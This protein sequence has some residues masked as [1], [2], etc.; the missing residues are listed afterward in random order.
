GEILDYVPDFAF[1]VRMGPAVQGRLAGHSA[2]RWS[3]PYVPAFRLAAELIAPALK[4]QP[5]P[6][7]PL[8]ARGFAGEPEEV[9][10]AGL[11]EAGIEVIRFWPDSGGGAVFRLRARPSQL[12]DLARLR[13]LAWIEPDRPYR[14]GNAVARSNVLI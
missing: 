14:L 1:I 13:A 4:G 11:R 8:L 9:I 2:L 12:L 6:A 7:M 10:R 3:G 5:G